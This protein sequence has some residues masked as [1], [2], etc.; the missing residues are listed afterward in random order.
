[1]WVTKRHL[2]EPTRRL[3][4]TFQTQ[5]GTEKMVS[6]Q[7]AAV[8]LLLHTYTVPPSIALSPW[9]LPPPRLRSSAGC[10]DQSRIPVGVADSPPSQQII[11][12]GRI[13]GSILVPGSRSV[14]TCVAAGL[15]ASPSLQY[16]SQLATKWMSAGPVVGNLLPQSM[17]VGREDGTL[18]QTV[19]ATLCH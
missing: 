11:K 19:S 6:R 4:R 14:D 1:M 17:C 2:Q 18:R 12:S 5:H 8:T 15:D 13:V 7:T 9:M 16:G 10:I 3:A